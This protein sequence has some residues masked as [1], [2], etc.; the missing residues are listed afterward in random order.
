MKASKV[1]ADTIR[2][3]SQETNDQAQY[4]INYSNDSWIEPDYDHLNMEFWW[5][6]NL[7]KRSGWLDDDDANETK[8]RGLEE[9]TWCDNQ[10]LL[11]LY[12]GRL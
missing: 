12:Y 1:D 5:S 6:S 8:M 2:T 9:W 3:A 7:E 4:I 10:L 11:P